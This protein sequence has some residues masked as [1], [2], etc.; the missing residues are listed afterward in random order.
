MKRRIRG[1]DIWAPLKRF[2]GR[3]VGLS[4]GCLP[5]KLHDQTRRRLRGEKGSTR[6]P[7]V[8]FGASPKTSTIA[9]D[10]KRVKERA[11]RRAA[12]TQSAA[13]LPAAFRRGAETN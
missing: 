12:R 11:G 1:R 9:S 7:R 8:V 3:E 4:C 2:E 5:T 6:A 13:T 10:A